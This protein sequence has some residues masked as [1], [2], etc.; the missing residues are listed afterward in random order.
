MSHSHEKEDQITVGR[1][2]KACFFFFI[3]VFNTLFFRV[4]FG[5]RQRL[6]V[7]KKKNLLFFSI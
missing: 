3:R 1:K 2:P 7:E 5:T 4:T 6:R